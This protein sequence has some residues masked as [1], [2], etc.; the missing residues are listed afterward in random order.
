V[1][2]SSVLIFANTFATLDNSEAEV[3]VDS[4]WETIRKKI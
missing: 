4:A 2:R 3:D 1:K